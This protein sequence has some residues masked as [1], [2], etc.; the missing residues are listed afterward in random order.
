[1]L[2]LATGDDVTILELVKL[3]NGVVG[4]E[5]DIVHDLSKKDGPPRKNNER[6]KKIRCTGLG[7]ENLFAEWL[8]FAA[9]QATFWRLDTPD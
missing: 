8:G 3:V 5:G 1:M 7:T 6:R 2:M 4:F 9:Y